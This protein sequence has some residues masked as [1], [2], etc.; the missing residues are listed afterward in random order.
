MRVEEFE[1]LGS[2]SKPQTFNTI[3]PF[4]K[5]SKANGLN[6]YEDFSRTL[7]QTL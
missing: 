6:F 1:I 7:D 2:T 4:K 3:H 5:I